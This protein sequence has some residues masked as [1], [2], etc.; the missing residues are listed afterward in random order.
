MIQFNQIE[1]AKQEN[2]AQAV[3][4]VIAKYFG[5]GF[6]YD[7]QWSGQGRLKSDVYNMK[8]SD[9]PKNLQDYD[10]V[11]KSVNSMRKDIKD[12]PFAA[13]FTSH[14]FRNTKNDVIGGIF[15]IT[16]SKQGNRFDFEI[17]CKD[18]MNRWLG[19]NSDELNNIH[20]R[21][22]ADDDL[23]QIARENFK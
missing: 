8:S 6:K 23:K 5:T 7:A 16:K 4:D 21:I 19:D 17:L 1:E 18:T 11:V 15:T 9:I 12:L 3:F 14:L 22:F 20:F 2:E 10:S 13:K